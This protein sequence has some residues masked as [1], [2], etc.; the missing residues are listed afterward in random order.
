MAFSFERL[1]VLPEF[2][3]K[4]NGTR[5]RP[6]SPSRDESDAVRFAARPEEQSFFVLESIAIVVREPHVPNLHDVGPP[7]MGRRGR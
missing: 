1:T 7:P 2:A 3:A 4:G 5:C 6:R